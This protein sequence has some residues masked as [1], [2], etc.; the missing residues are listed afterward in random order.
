ML[1]IETKLLDEL[2]KNP[3]CFLGITNGQRIFI[4][5][6]SDTNVKEILILIDAYDIWAHL[7]NY[8]G[9]WYTTLVIFSVALNAKNVNDLFENFW[10]RMELA[11]KDV[12]SIFW[13]P[14][15]DS[16]CSYQ[17]IY[18]KNNFSDAV[19]DLIFIINNYEK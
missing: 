3:A 8:D 18:K 9:Y 2:N 16:N 14:A 7:F 4:R 11:N 1:D 12:N 5:Y 17:A 6:D 13:F 19:K 15:N 10:Y